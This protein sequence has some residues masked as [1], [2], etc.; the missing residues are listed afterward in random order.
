M[1]AVLIVIFLVLISSVS[2]AEC[3][4]S[5]VTFDDTSFNAWKD[6]ATQYFPLSLLMAAVDIFVDIQGVS[7]KSPTD[8]TF[9]F[10]GS[11]YV[12]LAFMDNPV[13]DA[14][15]ISFR[16]VLLA[17]VCLQIVRHLLEYVL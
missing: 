12:P 10:F 11:T 4:S 15:M 3:D 5:L 2:Y 17:L 14:F 16:W 13:V 8:F 9:T 7:Q 6:S 1:K